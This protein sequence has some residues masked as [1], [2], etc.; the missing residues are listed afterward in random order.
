MSLIIVILSVALT[1]LLA[2]IG[3]DHFLTRCGANERTS[4][5]ASTIFAILCGIFLV[6]GAGRFLF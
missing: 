4:F 6:V 3:L 1:F 2:F 5:V